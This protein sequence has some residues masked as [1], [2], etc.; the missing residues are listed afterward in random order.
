MTKF[1]KALVLFNLVFS[2]LMA[3]WA[4]GVFTNRVD[5]SN[6]KKPDQVMGLL[7]QREARV[8]EV[9]DA[10]RPADAGWAR[11]RAAVYFQESFRPKLTAWYAEQL[12]NARDGNKE[13][14][15][16]DMTKEL[17]R[18]RDAASFSPV[19]T[20]PQ[21]QVVFNPRFFEVPAMV[22]PVKDAYGRPLRSLQAYSQ[23]E[24][25]LNKA[26]E[27]ERA[28]YQKAIEE[29]VRQTALLIGREAALQKLGAEQANALLDAKLDSK[30]LRQR[31]QDE[32]VKEQK[33]QEEIDFLKPLRVNVAVEHQLLQ[34][35]TQALERRIEELK[36]IGVAVR[37]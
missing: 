2:L 23:E 21:G 4:I 12:Q 17:A 14:G 27:N 15:E 16:V 36:K 7:A 33:L 9:K 24:Q 6:T 13:I 26:I 37:P 32:R 18:Q 8:K 3:V 10:F 5:F 30:G 19:V 35:R 22:V 25:G 20:G 34:K 1:G 11:A 28:R 31:L 29:D